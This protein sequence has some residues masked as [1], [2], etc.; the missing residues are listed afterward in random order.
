MAW[1]T[2]KT[3]WDSND[4]LTAAGINAIGENTAYLKTQIDDAKDD[5]DD[6]E[7]HADDTTIH[8]TSA[9]I[10]GE[11]GTPFYLERRTSDPASPGVGQ[12]WI[13]TDL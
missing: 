4:A 11:Y 1:S 9:T 2:P 6:L 10:R 13:R 12:M 8:K 5:I 3:D 7:A